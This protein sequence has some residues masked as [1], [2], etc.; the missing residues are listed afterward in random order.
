M[1]TLVLACGLWGLIGEKAQAENPENHLGSWV[2]ANSTLRLTDRWSL[3]A[4][5]EVRHWK[6]ASDLNEILLRGAVHYDFSPRVMGGLGY[7]Y[8]DF[9]PFEEGA[10]GG[11]DLTENRLYQQLALKQSWA[12]ATLEHRIRLEQRWFDKSG[13]DDY[14]PGTTDYS[15]RGRYR[16]QV[17]IPVNHESLQSGTYFINLNNETFLNIGEE[18]KVFD[19][20]RLAMGGGHQF[21]P[22]TNLQLGLLWQ[23][24]RSDNFFRL[25]LYYTH[26]FDLRQD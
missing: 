4:Q 11:R 10:N 23:A 20:N 13:V 6:L 1:V 9:S 2:G 7:V 24:R 21:T 25:Q 8:V 19:Q 26:N 17:V 18:E 14:K 3:F 22:Y 5:G 16:L 15:N 12:R